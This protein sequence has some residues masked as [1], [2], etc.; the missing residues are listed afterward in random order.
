VEER[1]SVAL[2]GAVGTAAPAGAAA[3]AAADAARAAHAAVVGAA[4]EQWRPW[5]SG[6]GGSPPLMGGCE[7]RQRVEEQ[8]MGPVVLRGG[9]RTQAA[10]GM[11]VGTR[12]LVSRAVVEERWR[13][14]V[15]MSKGTGDGS[16]RKYI[17]SVQIRSLLHPLA[18]SAAQTNA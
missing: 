1:V 16:P 6:A 17:S 10:F 2:D 13:W 4:L 5:R 7:R 11:L 15:M 8:A 14:S 18:L 12:V 9:K 3:G